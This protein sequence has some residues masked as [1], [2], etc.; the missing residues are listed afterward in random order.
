MR[1]D[2]RE[3][4]DMSD[5]NA[6]VRINIL[7]ERPSVIEFHIDTDTHPRPEGMVFLWVGKYLLEMALEQTD[8]EASIPRY[9]ITPDG[10]KLFI[11]TLYTRVPAPWLDGE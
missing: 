5:P 2:E 3:Y 11:V 6:A 10:K 1:V 9:V 8:I 4:V 7:T